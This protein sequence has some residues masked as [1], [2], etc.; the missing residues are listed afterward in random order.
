MV[1]GVEP[2]RFGSSIRSMRRKPAQLACLQASL[3]S[4]MPLADARASHTV[5]WLLHDARPSFTTCALWGASSCSVA[6]PAGQSWHA[7]AR[8]T[9]HTATSDDDATAGDAAQL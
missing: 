8:C 4:Y 3:V 1:A 5:L 6:R 7:S 2:K 9:L